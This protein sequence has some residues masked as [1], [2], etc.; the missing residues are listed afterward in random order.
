MTDKPRKMLSQM[1]AE[2]EADPWACPKCGCRDY[3]VLNTYYVDGH[4]RRRRCC[5]NCRKVVH[6]D[7]VMCPPG[8]RVVVLPQDEPEARACA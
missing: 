3:R 1:K 7:E 8:F 2:G 4:P 6:T 5:R